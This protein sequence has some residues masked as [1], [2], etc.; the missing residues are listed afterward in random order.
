MLEQIVELAIASREEN[1]EERGDD[2]VELLEV[3]TIKTKGKKQPKKKSQPAKPKAAKRKRN[4]SKAPE[5][6]EE[7]ENQCNVR[8]LSGIEVDAWNALILTLLQ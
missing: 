7:E 2:V 6:K 5:A 4:Q 3:P 1:K 8:L